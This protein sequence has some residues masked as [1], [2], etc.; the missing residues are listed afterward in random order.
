MFFCSFYTLLMCVNLMIKNYL[1]QNINQLR[2][3]TYTFQF[4]FLNLKMYLSSEIENET[5]SIKTA[6]SCYVN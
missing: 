3:L 4:F 1:I 6:H 2:V 5:D